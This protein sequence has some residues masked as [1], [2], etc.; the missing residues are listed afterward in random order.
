MEIAVSRGNVRRHD[1]RNEGSRDEENPPQC[2]APFV[3]IKEFNTQTD[4]MCNDEDRK[5]QY[6]PVDQL[7]VNPLQESLYTH[8]TRQS[9]DK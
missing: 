9:A 4:H 3:G 2:R 7:K 8:P 1:Q 5:N 6:K